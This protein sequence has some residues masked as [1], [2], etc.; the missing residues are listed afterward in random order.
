MQ[1][2]RIQNNNQYKGSFGSKVIMTPKSIE[3]LKEES[4]TVRRKF[5]KDLIT[6]Q[7]NGNK[8][9]VFIDYLDSYDNAP[10]RYTLQLIKKIKNKIHK[11]SA[12]GIYKTKKFDIEQAYDKA[13]K[14]LKPARQ[15]IFNKYLI[16]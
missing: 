3:F 13:N 2:Q 4:E 12:C 9:T 16:G 10:Y 14:E 5:N 15:D 8:D 11:S 1:I 6:L 7:K